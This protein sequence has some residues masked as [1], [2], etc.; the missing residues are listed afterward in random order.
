MQW[1]DMSRE[2]RDWMIFLLIVLINMSKPLFNTYNIKYTTFAMEFSLKL[3]VTMILCLV[4]SLIASKTVWKRQ[5]GS[6]RPKASQSPLTFRISNIPIEI[7]NSRFQDILRSAIAQSSNSPT[8]SPRPALLGWS[9]ARS[10]H[11]EQFLVGTV[12]L[13]SSQDPYQL[14]LT[15]EH[16]MGLE[17]SELRVDLDF[18][19]L[20]PLAYPENATVE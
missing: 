18:F 6:E 19:G 2:K 17:S 9:L 4:V 1:D 3:I 8:A 20:T 14:R 11:L 5:K 7:T 15:I 13:S 16:A 10:G 12:T